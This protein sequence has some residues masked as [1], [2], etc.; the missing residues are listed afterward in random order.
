MKTGRRVQRR[1]A[2][3]TKIIQKEKEKAYLYASVG[4]LNDTS[5]E[6]AAEAVGQG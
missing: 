4:E 6:L 3:S 1:L 5:A 2:A